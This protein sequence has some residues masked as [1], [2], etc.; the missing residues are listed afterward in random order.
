MIRIAPFQASYVVVSLSHS[1]YKYFS[2]A[3]YIFFLIDRSVVKNIGFFI[4]GVKI[5][6]ECNGMTLMPPVSV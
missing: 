2:F 1:A 3:L 6:L 4:L 5:A